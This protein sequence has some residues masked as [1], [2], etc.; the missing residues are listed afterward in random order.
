MSEPFDFLANP[1]VAAYVAVKKHLFSEGHELFI[2]SVT[3]YEPDAEMKSQTKSTSE[4]LAAWL[5]ETGIRV[6][7]WN[8]SSVQVSVTYEV[9]FNSGDPQW[10]TRLYE[11]NWWMFCRC[12][13]GQMN[14]IPVLMGTRDLCTGI[15]IT[16][17]RSGV[18]PQ[19]TAGKYNL[20][21]WNSMWQIVLGLDIPL[22]LIKT[23]QEV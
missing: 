12:V 21:G 9:L 3:S 15:D 16:D 6:D 19:Q 1:L 22:S 13:D 8:S 20:V 18:A 17:A 23:P 4:H 14:G 7:S 5:A 10:S 11:A 2:K